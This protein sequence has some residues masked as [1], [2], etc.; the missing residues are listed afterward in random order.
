MRQKIP[1]GKSEQ[2]TKRPALL[3]AI[4]LTV[5]AIEGRARLYRNLVVAVSAVLVLSILL[6][7][8]FHRWLPI[9]GFV[10]LAPLT[11]GFLYFDSR[12]VRRWRARIVEMTS[13]RSLERATFQKTISGFRQLPPNTLKSMLSTLP[14]SGEEGGHE[15]PQ[16]E[17]VIAGAEFDALERKNELKILRSTALLTGALICLIAGGF[18]RSLP[19]LATGGSLAIL[20]LALGRR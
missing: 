4:D 18:Y 2:P 10:L 14:A 16:P 11:G 1:A 3:D 20:L 7:V 13:L 15:T 17:K 12:L 8:L 9:S 19:L 6:S 5:R